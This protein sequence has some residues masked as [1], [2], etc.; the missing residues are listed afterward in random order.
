MVM[1]CSSRAL[2]LA[3]AVRTTDMKSDRHLLVYITFFFLTVIDAQFFYLD[4]NPFVIRML[5]LRL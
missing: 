1:R 4:E 3:T 2:L 5:A